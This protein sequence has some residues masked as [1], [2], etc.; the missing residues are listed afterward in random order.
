M[1]S[2]FVLPQYCKNSLLKNAFFNEIE[3]EFLGKEFGYS[4]A[5]I[6]FSSQFERCLNSSPP[7]SPTSQAIYAKSKNTHL[8]PTTVKT[9][10]NYNKTLATPNRK[11]FP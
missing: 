7:L 5:I 11:K 6:K 9:T 3:I 4:T 10:T 8:Q 1:Y 2:C